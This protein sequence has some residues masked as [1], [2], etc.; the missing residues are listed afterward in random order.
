MFDFYFGSPFMAAI[1]IREMKTSKEMCSRL[2][3]GFAHDSHRG[4]EKVIPVL[5][6]ALGW[7][8]QY[9]SSLFT[10]ECESLHQWHRY[11]IGKE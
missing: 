2:L 3:I 8:A 5:C 9:I 4:V 6:L 1:N 11:I 7:S 10:I